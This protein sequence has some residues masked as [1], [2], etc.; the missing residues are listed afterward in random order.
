MISYFILNHPYITAF[1]GSVLRICF[2]IYLN[3]GEISVFP[4]GLGAG[5]IISVFISVVDAGLR[6]DFGTEDKS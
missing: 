4:I 6:K 3:T 5:G 1:M 2:G